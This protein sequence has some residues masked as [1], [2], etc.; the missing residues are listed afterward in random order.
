MT[1][2]Y[3]YPDASK[4]NVVRNGWYGTFNSGT[5]IQELALAPDFGSSSPAG[6]VDEDVLVP[7][8]A[9]YWFTPNNNATSGISHLAFEPFA[10][11]PQSISL[12]MRVQPTSGLYLRDVYLYYDSANNPTMSQARHYFASGYTT[13]YNF[14]SGSYSSV[15]LSLTKTN[16]PDCNDYLQLGIPELEF[17]LGST[18]GSGHKVS[19]FTLFGS[20]TTTYQ[21]SGTLPLYIN[22]PTLSSGWLDL[23][24]A[25]ESGGWLYRTQDRIRFVSDLTVNGWTT[26]NNSTTNLYSTIDKDHTDIS[27]FAKL[28]TISYNYTDFE[29]TASNRVPNSITIVANGSGNTLNGI[30]FRLNGVDLGYLDWTTSGLKS[31]TKILDE[32]E[33]NKIF[34][35]A[36]KNYLKQ[37]LTIY[38]SGMS[39][40]AERRL[41]NCEI[42]YSGG[43]FD[44][45]QN[46]NGLYRERLYPV[47]LEYDY[48]TD[49]WS[50]ASG[51][52]P[53]ISFFG[54]GSNSTY[55]RKNIPSAQ[56]S[57]S[58]WPGY[59]LPS[60]NLGLH[61]NS[62]LP[63]F[64]QINKA[65]LVLKVQNSG[66]NFSPAIFGENPFI[67]GHPTITTRY[68]SPHLVGFGD[69]IQPS[70]IT[71][72]VIPLQF[73]DP[74]GS[75][76]N[77]HSDRLRSIECF[78]N[79][80]L[81][82]NSIPSGTRIYEAYVDI[83]YN[84]GT[85]WCPL[86][87]VGQL[88]P[89]TESY[90]SSGLFTT[91]FA[92]GRPF[93]YES[94]YNHGYYKLS[95]RSGNTI[96]S[97]TGSQSGVCR[98]T[99]EW[100]NYSRHGALHRTIV[101]APYEDA[102]YFNSGNINL[103]DFGSILPNNGSRLTDFTIYGKVNVSGANE[104]N[105]TLLY[106]GTDTN[107]NLAFGVSNG[108]PSLF[109]NDLTNTQLIPTNY[110]LG[111]YNSVVSSSF[112]IK[113]IYGSGFY[114]A[115]IDYSPSYIL[116][117]ISFHEY[118]SPISLLGGDRLYLGGIPLSGTAATNYSTETS[119]GQDCFRGWLHHFGISSSAI[120]T[121]DLRRQCD[122][123]NGFYS[124]LNSGNN[125]IQFLV[126]YGSGTTSSNSLVK[127]QLFDYPTSMS[128]SFLLSDEHRHLIDFD[129]YD[130]PTSAGYGSVN[131][132]PSAI[133]LELDYDHH[134]NHPSGLT[135]YGEVRTYYDNN[136]HST[137]FETVIG[138]GSRQTKQINPHLVSL[139][140]N[141]LTSVD[142]L[143]L[144]KAFGPDIQFRYDAFGS[145]YTGD[146][147]LYGIKTYFDGWSVPET[148]TTTLN[149]Y[150][151]GNYGGNATLDL[152]LYN[153]T[154]YDDVD[155][156]LYGHQYTSGSLDL[157]LLGGLQSS[158]SLDLYMSGYPSNTW[159]PLHTI[160]GYSQ[161]TLDLYEA[162][163]LYTSGNVNLYALGHTKASGLFNLFIEGI[164]RETTS[165]NLH[166]TAGESRSASGSLDL[167][168]WST[169]N[170]GLFAQIP[171]S[172]NVGVVP[173]E[174][175]LPLHMLGGGYYGIG[176]GN[177][178]LVAF[179]D[180]LAY[181]SIDLFL[182]N[183]AQLSSGTVNL[184]CKAPSGTYGAIPVS[185]NMDLVMGREYDGAS[186]SLMM[187]LLGPVVES[188]ILGMYI[189]GTDLKESGTLN[190]IT[191]G[192]TNFSSVKHL[193]IHGF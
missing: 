176:S 134:T 163:H 51:T 29:L 165:L 66:H 167:Y 33:K 87:I 96:Y 40:M 143:P 3:I 140:R 129:Y 126:P 135:L 60:G 25:N 187:T 86:S 69:K 16:N 9:D 114:L 171:L 43:V 99:P 132:N 57:N 153:N 109:I 6:Y 24:V 32:Q 48:T 139:N 189:F 52:N 59:S 178:N 155:L 146:F 123:Y 188:G 12:S 104:A 192:Y 72:Y 147:K 120:S 131:I 62:N 10:I 128:Y 5:T 98:N 125:H 181:N 49:N 174:N 34:Y 105:K 75:G 17:N 45:T 28:S 74:F 36:R 23:I 148:G 151:S 170:S 138:S 177:L 100:W 184:F 4:T 154:A 8:D 2:R 13:P 61:F 159:I 14:S 58:I 152:F 11:N 141:N 78:K 91:G 55:I 117:T 31:F 39:F 63:N 186:I 79:L 81:K 164:Y 136:W 122:T 95:E 76:L 85:S 18:Q 84:S 89:K 35:D 190:L 193:Y 191:T 21:D 133:R 107:W 106:Y 54:D 116:D 108:S 160:A 38:N 119:M 47:K 179:N 111:F 103:I 182:Q 115:N 162:G 53:E 183:S 64:T 71:D 90:F 158:G 50:S 137:L 94:L 97:M 56:R 113:Y 44:N 150:T 118:T 70:L 42:Y 83:F 169:T 19:V 145:G 175:V 168:T 77:H 26:Q 1:T 27:T 22:G 172:L 161:T 15:S 101:P 149:L 142:S 166:T 110:I 80:E 68:A 7:I 156:Y 92:Q 73:V 46:N 67:Q 20:G 88:T 180:N 130:T 65:D 157:S 144:Y 82:I 30:A 37:Y 102:L 127:D 112:L 173:N 185:G 121:T 124:Y 93:N 41:Y